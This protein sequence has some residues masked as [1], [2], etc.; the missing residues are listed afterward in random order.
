MGL[1]RFV[2]HTSVHQPLS[3]KGP[4]FSLGPFG[5]W[6][7]RNETWSGAGAKAWVDYLARSSFLLQQGQF[8]RR[9]RL[10]LRRGLEH[11]G[12]LRQGAAAGPGRL[13]LRLRQR[14][15]AHASTGVEGRRAGD[16]IGHALP[17]TGA[18]SAQPCT[19]RFRCCAASAT[20]SPRAA[21]SPA[22]KPV[23]YAEPRG[24]RARVPGDR[25]RAVGRRLGGTARLR[26]GAR[27]RRDAARSGAARARASRR[28]SS[29]RS[30]RPTPSCSSCTAGSAT[31]SCTS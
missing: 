20:S 31:A 27:V 12:A 7:T 16:G 9:R 8:R 13:Q 10:V 14:R 21:W 28:T 5:Q 26:Q 22:L 29:T 30:P 6:F 11:H 3:D 4:G 17:R 19:C 1:N 15:C 23:D 25:R 2:I 18:R 24:R